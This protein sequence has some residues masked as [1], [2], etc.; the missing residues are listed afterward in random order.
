MVFCESKTG[1]EEI[2][3][4]T[5]IGEH[6]LRILPMFGGCV[7]KQQISEENGEKILFKYGLKKEKFYFYPAQFWAHKNHRNLVQAFAR[8]Q[9]KYPELKLVLSGSDK[10]NR[11]YIEQ[12]IKDLDLMSYVVFLGFVPLEE[13]YCMYKYAT[14]LVMASHFGPTNMPPIEAMEIGC[15]VACSDLGGHHEILGDAAVYF[16]SYDYNTISDAME[17]VYMENNEYRKRILSRRSITI[18]S[19]EKALMTLDKLLIE[20][21]DVRSNWK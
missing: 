7:T 8:V 1:I 3:K 5:N 11:D 2:A 14:A 4:Y 13:L 16:D 6:K 18:Y 19:E 20:A 9:K 15:P 17:N 21:S 12:I 10:G